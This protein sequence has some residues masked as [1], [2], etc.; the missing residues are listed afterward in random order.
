MIKYDG[1]E[2]L[3]KEKGINR[4]DLRAFLAPMTLAKM[5]KGQN[6]NT[7]NINKLCKFLDCQPGD[8]MRFEEA[9]GEE[10]FSKSDKARLIANSGYKTVMEMP[11]DE[12]EKGFI[13]VMKSAYKDSKKKVKE[14]DEK[15]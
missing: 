1:L 11:A 14:I 2:K 13:N 8:I 12:I 10:I 9:E 4:T 5:K 3:L 7:D 6:I 15:Y